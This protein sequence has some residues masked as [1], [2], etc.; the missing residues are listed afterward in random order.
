MEKVDRKY[1]CPVSPYEDRPEMIGYNATISAPHM[2]A[3]CLEILEPFLNENS[4]VLDVGCGS[5]YLTACFGK[6]CGKVYGIEHIQGLV[7]L[8]KD[9]IAK[10]DI[11]M[12]QS[13]KV[14][15]LLGD[16][17]K[18]IHGKTFDAIHV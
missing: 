15:I 5:G 16:G 9:N 17:R 11:D 2:H 8:S 13:G 4:K 12:I 1:F 18:G 14:K 10:S 3:Y 6:L 7:D